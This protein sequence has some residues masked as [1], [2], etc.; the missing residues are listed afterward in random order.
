MS[1]RIWVGLFFCVFGLGFLLHQA[2]LIDFTQ[3]LSAWWPIIVMSVGIIQLLQRRASSV[4]T[5][6]LLFVVGL[7]FLLSHW[8]GL[9]IY[10]YIWPLIF[11][12]IGIIII[13][14]RIKQEK[15]IEESDDL[16][17]TV[18]LSGA[19]IRSQSKSFQGGSVLTILGGAEIDLRDAVI[20]DGAKID[21]TSILGGVSILVPENVRVELSGIPL[22]GGWEDSTRHV[23]LTGEEV[24][25]KVQCLTIL[26]GAEIKN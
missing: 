11:I 6:I 16:N 5:G 10:S 4:I 23:G 18:L 12:F 9:D 19:E 3:V 7:L 14:T 22:L 25:L 13:F 20:V 8:F 21:I 15:T 24:V 26:G 2:D 17:T 1:G